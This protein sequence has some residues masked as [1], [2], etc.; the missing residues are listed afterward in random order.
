MPNSERA[1]AQPEVIVRINSGLGNQLF[2]F[3]HG[4]AL[5]ERMGG[6]LTYDTTWFSIVAGLHPVRRRLRLQELNIRLPEA[7][8]GARRLAVGITAAFFD[9]F[10]RGKTLLSAIGN[11][12][13]IQEDISQSD[14]IEE[15]CRNGHGRLYL[16]GYWQTNCSYMKVHEKLLRE[17]R[18]KH[19]LSI[20]AEAL[21]AKV[22]SGNTGFVHVR[23]GDYIHFMGDK[24]LLPLNYYS[25][26]LAKMQEIGKGIDYWLIFSEDTAW[27]HTNMQFFPNAEI[28]DYQSPNRDIEDLMI[29]KACFA[30]IIANSSYSW[31]GAA[32][33]E[34][35][36]RPI[37]APDKYWPST[38]SDTRRWALPTWHRAKAW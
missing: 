2:Q 9:K 5:A 10:G 21:I 12:K 33:G 28:V 7:F 38:C 31:W 30:G 20:G 16:N 4:M 37:I 18:P 25:N 1:R 34:H 36:D 19:R 35:R 32:L 22:S 23:R 29:M 8:S 15:T 27:A 26:A 24:G 3:A 13:V 11:M 17:L 14:N 6:R